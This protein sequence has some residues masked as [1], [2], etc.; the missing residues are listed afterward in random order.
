MEVHAT[1]LHVSLASANDA[2]AYLRSTS[3]TKYA[4]RVTDRLGC[5]PLSSPRAEPLVIVVRQADT[6]LCRT[7]GYCV[8]MSQDDPWGR[9]IRGCHLGVLCPRTPEDPY[10]HTRLS[11]GTARRSYARSR[12]RGSHED[13]S[14]GPPPEDI[15]HCVPRVYS[16]NWWNLASRIDSATP[17]CAIALARIVAV[18]SRRAACD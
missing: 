16:F 6:T 11:G 10:H 12:G 15:K 14:S 18:S 8:S 4:F 2:S 9:R 3:P 1:K 13:R 17:A 7:K 5:P